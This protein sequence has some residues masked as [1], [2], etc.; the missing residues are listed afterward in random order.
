MHPKIS[1]IVPVYNAEKYLHRCVDS[2]LAQSYT[3][4]EL[5]LVDDGSIDGGS[6]ICDEYG[7]K[8][9]RVR[10]F[11][12]ENGGVSSAR[13][14]GIDNARGEYITFC[15]ADDY[16]EED[17]LSVYTTAMAENV[18]VAIQGIYYMKSDGDVE[19]KKL[20][21]F[22]GNGIVAK[23]CI[24]VELFNQ[25]VYGYPVTKLFSH[26]II[27]E[28]HIRFDVNSTFREDA[29]FFSKY[30][31]YV[32]S[33]ICIDKENYYYILPTIDKKYNGDLDYSLFPILQ[34]MDVIF[35]KEIPIEICRIYYSSVKTIAIQKVINREILSSYHM[36][37][38]ERMSATL[39]Y[40]KG[41]K[42]RLVNSMI[43]HSHMHPLLSRVFL[44]LVK[45]ITK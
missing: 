4:F 16:V 1:V 18:D 20:V 30:M 29:Q 21:A 44:S 26:R 19:T 27:E 14:L 23:R 33:F 34:S 38:Y 35:D 15:D 22:A 25:G 5:L 31:E 39:G 37:L 42:K 8:D 12:Q 32:D 24:I 10:V 40:N 43:L 28:N 7:L 13:N 41:W 3:D 36:N 6:I 17:W 11:H 2:I 45:T 9:S